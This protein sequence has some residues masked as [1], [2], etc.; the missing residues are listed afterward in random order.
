MFT[1][2]WE[3]HWDYNHN[4]YAYMSLC[5]SIAFYLRSAGL[6]DNSNDN[7]DDDNDDI[8]IIIMVIIVVL[9]LETLL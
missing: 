9:V 1:Y 4:V 6:C 5:W 8:V 7:N 2:G 3:N